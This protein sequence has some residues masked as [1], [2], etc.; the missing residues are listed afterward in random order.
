MK[1]YPRDKVMIVAFLT[2]GVLSSSLHAQM[3][4]R[5]IQEAAFQISADQTADFWLNGHHLF[6]QN[7]TGL[8]SGPQTR[9]ALADHLCF[10][11]RDNT[12][13]IRVESPEHSTIGVAYILR[14]V[15]SDG[16]HQIFTSSEVDQHRALY[17]PGDLEPYGW[18]QPGFDD[19]AWVKAFDAG[20][21]PYAAIL[22][23][24]DGDQVAFLS[25][26]GSSGAVS[27]KGEKQLFRIQ[28]HLD[29][30]PNPRCEAPA[31]HPTP[32]PFYFPQEAALSP[33]PT[34]VPPTPTPAVVTDDGIDAPGRQARVMDSWEAPETLEVHMAPTIF[35]T[36]TPLP[37]VTPS[38]VPA[39]IQQPQSF[40]VSLMDG[41]GIYQLD[42]TDDS[43]EVIQTL[44]KKTLTGSEEVW[45]QWDGKDA[46]GRSVPVKAYSLLYSK[47]GRIIR[48]MPLSSN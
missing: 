28:F 13:A 22:P 44:L 5:Y 30:L 10:F 39:G 46:A 20:H 9:I 31:A 1:W 17:L 18:Q 3:T 4:D 25:A 26:S 47:D 41:P 23:D 7:Y 21:V 24:P 40:Y 27:Q 8:E 33:T 12:L 43:G 38:P 37:A 2:V 19:H 32:T 34:W 45:V 15:L 36:G 48:K 29:V 16:S 35:P 11:Q 14:L 6:T 42:V